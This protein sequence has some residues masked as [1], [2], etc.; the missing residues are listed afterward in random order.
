M[1]QISKSESLVLLKDDKEYYK[2]HGKNFLSNSDINALLR[3]PSSF[4]VD[5]EDSK[6]MAQGR[7][8]HQLMLEPDKANTF[9]MIDA[10]TRNTNKYID[11]CKSVG[12]SFCLL[13]HEVKS[14]HSWVNAMRSN[15]HFYDE[16]YKNGN[17]FEVPGISEIK[18]HMFKG[19]TDIE[20]SN[21]LPD[22][23]TT[24]DIN[25]FSK[26]GYIYN[27]DSQAY[28]YEQIF[29][30]P[31]VFFVV[32]KETLQLGIFR[33]TKEFVAS[34]ERKVERALSVYDKYFGLNKTEDII[35][36]YIDAEI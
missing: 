4:G 20:N 33:P 27:Y 12:I 16:I 30:K 18:G 3:N 23:K 25:K 34:G 35:N 1:S 8:F 36:H 13:M 2:G 9:H 6:E 19:K 14:V 24:T 29:G 10:S 32:D 22:L 31:V 15:I 7:L 21:Y 11:Y 5:R 28:I 17:K 26:S